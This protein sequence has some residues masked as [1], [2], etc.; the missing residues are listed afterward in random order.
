M[1][2]PETPK[3]PNSLTVNTRRTDVAVGGQSHQSCR[4]DN[5]VTPPQPQ[6]PSSRWTPPPLDRRHKQRKPTA[7][8]LAPKET[9]PRAAPRRNLPATPAKNRHNL[10]ADPP[11]RGRNCRGYLLTIFPHTTHHEIIIRS[12]T[13]NED[14][15]RCLR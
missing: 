15:G 3:S 6:N 4:A 1:A 10:P 5:F 11:H 13:L 9:D 8:T 2:L 7:Q 14:V 12:R